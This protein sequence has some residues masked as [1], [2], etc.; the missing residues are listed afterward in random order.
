MGIIQLDQHLQQFSQQ[1]GERGP[2]ASAELH[3]HCIQTY[4]Q[5][6]PRRHSLHKTDILTRRN[7]YLIACHIRKTGD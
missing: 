2:N 6:C 3:E 1:R 5:Y 7:Q 4:I